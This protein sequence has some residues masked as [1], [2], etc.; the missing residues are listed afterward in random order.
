M[1]SVS[2]RKAADTACPAKIPQIMRLNADRRQTLNQLTDR[3]SVIQAARIARFSSTAEQFM[4]WVVDDT[5]ARV[6]QS[7][8][9]CLSLLQG[10]SHAQCK[11]N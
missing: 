3:S 6:K 5:P 11:V 10:K 4:A 1:I 8:S 2:Q 7:R 9:D